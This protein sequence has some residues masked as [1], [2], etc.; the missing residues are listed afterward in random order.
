MSY[1]LLLGRVPFDFDNVAELISAHLVNEPPRPSELVPDVD[2]ELEKLLLKMVAK[3]PSKRP[4]LGEIRR[5]IGMQISASS[6]PFGL[7]TPPAGI[8]IPTDIAT[9]PPTEPAPP[10]P[11]AIVDAPPIASM[12]D[13]RNKR[14]A[15]VG[16]ALL[17]LAIAIA[18]VFVLS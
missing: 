1:E 11:V 10:P 3:D 17:V 15:V 7:L 16:I 5:V 2:P 9:S 12:V 8:P 4:P 6:Q 14:L 18:L 13:L